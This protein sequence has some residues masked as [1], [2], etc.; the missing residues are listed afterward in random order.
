MFRI[1]TMNKI[2]P[3]GLS[4]FPQ[5]TYT[6]GD[7]VSEPHAILVRSADLNNAAI[8][9]SVLGIARAGAGYNNIPVAKCSD[10][11]I[12]VFNTPGANANAVKELALAAMLIASR[13]IVGGINWAHT[14]AGK[15]AEVPDLVEKEKSKFEGGELRGK[16]LGVIGLGA[17]GSMVASAALA[18]D[19]KVVGYDPAL[20]I[21][22][23]WNLSSQVR[24]AETLE[25]LLGKSDY[26]SI[27]V[28][29]LDAT[30]GL[31]NSENL[32]LVKKDARILNLS[33]S[34][35][36]K[37]KDIVEAL[38]AG[39][40]GAYVTDFPTAE[41]L[42]C[43]KVIPIPHLG[44]STPEAEENC[45]YMA[46]RQLVDYLETGTIINSV[47]FP[48]L[49]PDTQRTPVR[50]VLLS[51]GLDG[52]KLATQVGGKLGDAKVDNVITVVGGDGYGASVIDIASEP[53]P[54]V[55][56]SINKLEGIVRVNVLK[57]PV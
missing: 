44:A 17:I 14:I 11:G 42:A 33:R 47:N 37:D 6:V 39:R 40:L 30:K 7:N 51:R 23:A 18:L 3:I 8:A 16:T 36:V 52:A 22:G 46:A 5:G 45:A 27:H 4:E 9:P 31:I 26:I 35:L 57:K 2:S 29:L 15:G 13:D 19:M 25:S 12:V 38:E 28:P 56:D 41:L 1:Q 54:E 10:S 50:L 43:K 24:R 48:R 34:G 49:R 32:R 20:T 21:E 55:L 53:S